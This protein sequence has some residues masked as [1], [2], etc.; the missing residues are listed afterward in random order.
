[1]ARAASRSAIATKVFFIGVFLSI[2]YGPRELRI[3]YRTLRRP[4]NFW[5]FWGYGVGA[6][7][8]VLFEGAQ[9][10]EVQEGRLLMMQAGRNPLVALKMAK[11][12]LI[13]QKETAEELGIRKGTC[14][15]CCER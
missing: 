2:G 8:D 1:V 5:G 10:A 11:K 14:F 13:T 6:K 4:G 12:K 15:V 7:C 9:A 3:S